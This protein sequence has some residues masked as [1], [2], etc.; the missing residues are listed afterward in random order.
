MLPAP[1]AIR[2]AAGAPLGPIRIAV[3][4]CAP[5]VLQPQ[6]G[7]P[8]PPIPSCHAHPGLH[9]TWHA[10]PALTAGGSGS[11]RAYPFRVRFWAGQSR[12]RLREPG[13]DTIMRRA[14]FEPTVGSVGVPKLALALC[15][16][17]ARSGLAPTLVTR[18]ATDV[19]P[20]V[21]APGRIGRGEGSLTLVRVRLGTAPSRTPSR[22]RSCGRISTPFQPDCEWCRRRVRRAS[23]LLSPRP[24]QGSAK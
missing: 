7:K 14:G 3:V 15:P 12:G 13:L 5:P 22:A 2:H 16:D 9:P 10:R 20:A 21:R 18:F 23:C 11:G 19:V 6:R 4:V 17:R 24:E 8:P 1:T